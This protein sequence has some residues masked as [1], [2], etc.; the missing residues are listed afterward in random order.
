DPMTRGDAVVIL[1]GGI[2]VRPFVAADLY[3]KGVVSKILLSQVAEDRPVKIGAYLGHTELNRRV[4]LKLGVP[5]SAIET[6]GNANKDTLDE[7]I[8]LKEWTK[9]NAV[10][11]L[12]IPTE[13]FP[14]R[15]VRWIFHREFYEKDIQIEIP[16]FEPDSYSRADW[17]KTEQGLMTFQN[18]VI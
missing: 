2:S 10:S 13:I 4:L 16:S 6:F 12:I 5:D 14:A 11:V 9:K 1:G 18:E 8:A 15:R 17:W 3:Q 7:A